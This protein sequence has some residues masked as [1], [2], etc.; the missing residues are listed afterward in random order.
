M[1]A[2]SH[3]FAFAAQPAADRTT[4]KKILLVDDSSTTHMWIKMILS[5][6]E[7]DLLSAR[8]GVE[9]VDLALAEHPDLI[10]MDVV[11]PRMNGFEAT[12]ALRTHARTVS[13]PIV[14]VTT[15][16]EARNVEAGYESGCSDYITKPIDGLELLSKVKSLLG[17][18]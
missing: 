1:Y 7:Y 11:M 15:R 3:S 8:D 13:T 2:P 14:M 5:K 12:R 6:S 16:S 18:G 4:R 17:D 10:L 9:G